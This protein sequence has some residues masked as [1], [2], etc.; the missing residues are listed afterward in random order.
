MEV[1]QSN[2]CGPIISQIRARSKPPITQEDLSARLQTYGL[3]IDRVTIAKIETQ[4][5]RV[6]DYEISAFCKVLKVKASTLLGHE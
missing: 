3:E 1:E 2:I 6:Y 4:R 5:R